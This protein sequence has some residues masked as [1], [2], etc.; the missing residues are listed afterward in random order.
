VADA[1]GTAWRKVFNLCVL[2]NLYGEIGKPELG[3]QVLATVSAT[4]REAFYAAEVLRLEADLLLRADETRWREAETGLTS[5]LEIATARQELSLALRAATSLARLWKK[6]GRRE[7]AAQ[8]LSAVYGQFT[9]GFETAD[10]QA[11]RELLSELGARLPT[12]A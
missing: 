4:H 2:A 6:R 7:E 10:L 1:A 12:R 5:A 9:E 8:R 11:A 3:R